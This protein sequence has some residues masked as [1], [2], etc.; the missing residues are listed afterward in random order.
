MIILMGVSEN[1]EL[2]MRRHAN[3]SLSDGYT[4][5]M[6]KKLKEKVH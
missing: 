2:G 5:R 6:K 4:F 3:L 1:N